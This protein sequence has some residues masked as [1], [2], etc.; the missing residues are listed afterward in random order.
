MTP[1]TTIQ[2]P[3]TK[4]PAGHYSQ[5]IVANG[6][7][8]VAGQVPMNLET[9]VPEIGTVEQQT[10]LALRNTAR[11][12]KAAGTSLANAVQM[13]VYLSS[14]EHWGAV[15]AAYARIMGEH[16]PARATVPI[17]PLHYGAAVEIQCIAALPPKRKRPTVRRPRAKPARRQ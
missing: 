2:T 9:G 11:I 17:S 13:T 16:R 15:N 8:F 6:F 3:G 1:F 14:I 10:E 4:R 12:L 5:A 7:V